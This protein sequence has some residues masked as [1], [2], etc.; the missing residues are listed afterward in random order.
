MYIFSFKSIIL[1]KRIFYSDL[2]IYRKIVITFGM[3]INKIYTFLIFYKGNNKL[4][5]QTIRI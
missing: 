2:L 1:C 5:F 4:T 3:F